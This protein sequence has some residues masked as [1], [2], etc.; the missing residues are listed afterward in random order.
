M[1]SR[2]FLVGIVAGLAAAMGL[3][4]L[5][6]AISTQ[7]AAQMMGGNHMGMMGNNN[8]MMMGG[9]TQVMPHQASWRLSNKVAP[10]GSSGVS[11]VQDVQVTGISISSDKQVTVNLRY[12]GNGTTP[13][14]VVMAS[15]GSMG[16]MGGH[17]GMG[18]MAG[19][20]SG[21]G[22]M[23]SQMPTMGYPMYGAQMHNAWND[24]QWQQW[25]SQMAQW[26]R[27][28]SN[29][30]SFDP[31]MN[32]HMMMAMVQGHQ[33]PMMGMSWQQH[34]FLT[35]STALDSGWSS[36]TTTVRVTLVGDGSAY[37]TNNVNVIVYP[38]TG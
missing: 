19:G 24:T 32:Q 20:M 10:F 23:G 18:M 25:H 2:I 7:S 12:T 13:D 37:D 27:Q 26:H 8:M 14:V 16:M 30:S 33:M 21:M 36:N 35:G 34:S 22:M 6:S 4:G 17:G 1:A 3:A 38:L 29:Q 31:M 11:Y 28:M 15:T 9:N 5:F